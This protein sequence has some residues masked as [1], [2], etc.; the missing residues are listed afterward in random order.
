[1]HMHM[2]HAHD[3]CTCTC[4]SLLE[5]VGTLHV[6][7]SRAVGLR[8][9][10]LAH[11]REPDAAVALTLGASFGGPPAVWSSVISRSAQPTWSADFAF[12]VDAASL[13]TDGARGPGDGLA[14]EAWHHDGERSESLGRGCIDVRVLVAST[15]LG[16]GEPIPCSAQLA[17]GQPTPAEVYLTLAWE[18]PASCEPSTGSLVSDEAGAKHQL[19]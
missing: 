3:T 7:L 2:T 10:G 18:G 8:H 14:I 4:P 15:G 9:V 6:H 5:Q 19:L 12:P 11:T 17:D 13:L 16:R 1:M